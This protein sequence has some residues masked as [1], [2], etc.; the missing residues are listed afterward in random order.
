M[1][2][3]II[4]ASKAFLPLS[5]GPRR[6][7][8]VETVP[9]KRRKPK[10]PAGPSHATPGIRRL[11][12]RLDVVPRPYRPFMTASQFKTL[13]NPKPGQHGNHCQLQ[14]VIDLKDSHVSLRLIAHL[15]RPLLPPIHGTEALR[16]RVAFLIAYLTSKAQYFFV[17]RVYSRA[18]KQ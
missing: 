1:N 12:N 16:I 18:G 5:V 7:E 17:L 15:Y 6:I 4:F 10:G 11:E 9:S 3:Q 13:P 2:N 8:T 14:E